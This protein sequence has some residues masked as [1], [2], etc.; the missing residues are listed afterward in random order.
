[1]STSAVITSPD[2]LA[3]L[4]VSSEILSYTAIVTLDAAGKIEKKGLNT[5]AKKVAALEAA[6]YEGKEQIAFKQNVSRPVVGTLE[7]FD[8]LFPDTD[9]KLYI[10]NY[11]LARYADAKARA[12]L[13]ETND[14][15]TEFVFQPTD[16][17]YDLTAEVQQTPARK[18][19]N[20]EVTINNLRKMGVTDEVIRSVFASLAAAKAQAVTV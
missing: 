11:G 2:T 15:D 7:G 20:E 17:T 14:D 18:L 3:T 9:S 4:P 6:D 10:I 5:S 12:V 1:M 19:T 8:S 16:G 13:L